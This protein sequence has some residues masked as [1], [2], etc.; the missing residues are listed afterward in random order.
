MAT[1][2]VARAPIQRTDGDGRVPACRW[3]KEVAVDRAAFKAAARGDKHNLCG[4]SR[5]PRGT[6]FI[7]THKTPAIACRTPAYPIGRPSLTAI[8][9]LEELSDRGTAARHLLYRLNLVEAVR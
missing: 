8:L 5:V 2:L 9:A 3:V 6:V 1:A 7:P 4:G